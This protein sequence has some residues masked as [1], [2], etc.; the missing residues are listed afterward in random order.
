MVHRV[1]SF[2][3]R[4]HEVKHSYHPLTVLRIPDRTNNI[5]TLLNRRRADMLA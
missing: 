1:G 3:E 2:V 4:K 5:G